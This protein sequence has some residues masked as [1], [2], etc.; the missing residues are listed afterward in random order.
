[1]ETDRNVSEYMAKRN[2]LACNA[3]RVLASQTLIVAVFFYAY[4]EL[5]N[6]ESRSVSLGTA[7]FT[8][9]CILVLLS[10][11]VAIAGCLLTA[12]VSDIVLSIPDSIGLRQSREIV[13]YAYE[14]AKDVLTFK[15]T[16]SVVMLTAGI[17]SVLLYMTLVG[18]GENGTLIGRAIL[19]LFLSVSILIFLPSFDRIVTYRLM[20]GSG[21]GM[22]SGKIAAGANAYNI[23]DNDT[24]MYLRV[25]GYTISIL[26]PSSIALYLMWRYFGSNRS[27]AFIIF[28][29]ALMILCAICAL[30]RK[31]SI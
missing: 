17:V 10:A 3:S 7:R 15:I 21:T 16:I 18:Y 6:W 14:K 19:F 29:V 2:K 13:K 8:V 1:M 24:G 5:Q 28:P 20:L 4:Y 9:K 26:L 11:L 27:Q 23:S 22:M 25:L 30:C 12:K 31:N